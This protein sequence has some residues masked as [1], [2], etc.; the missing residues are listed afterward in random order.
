MAPVEA[1]VCIYPSDVR[2][3]GAYA[4]S[5]SAERQ[6]AQIIRLKRRVLRT[7]QP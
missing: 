7:I 2:P 6:A 3:Q 4:E 5:T 1:D